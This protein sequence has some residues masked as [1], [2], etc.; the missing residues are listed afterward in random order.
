MPPN[1][2]VHT[3]TVR[4]LAIVVLA[5]VA[6]PI[7]ARAESW[8]ST[9]GELLRTAKRVEMLDVTRIAGATIDAQLAVAVRTTSAVGA[10]IKVEMPPYMPQ[11]PIAVGDRIL[12]ICDQLCPRAI[13][14]ERGGTFEVV[15]Q[16]PG[17]T[18]K[19]WPDFVERDSVALLAS[20]NQAPDVCL[21]GT[22]ALLDEAVGPRFRVA[23]TAGAGS[24]QGDLDGERVTAQRMYLDDLALS[25]PGVGASLRV[26]RSGRLAK[27]KD[28]CHTG[29]FTLVGPLPRSRAG[30]KRVLAGTAAASVLA[31]GT[32]D[33]AAGTA[34]AAGRY[35]FTIEIDRDGQLSV[36]SKLASGSAVGWQSGGTGGGHRVYFPMIKKPEI[37]VVDFGGGTSTLGIAQHLRAAGLSVATLV[38]RPDSTGKDTPLGSMK[39]TYVPEP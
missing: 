21:A 25:L 28:G 36:A 33:V 24:G 38:T 14:V 13:G 29:S 10:S 16:Q 12:V 20:A 17:N 15:A 35:P 3:R 9:M 34:V 19:V 32:L 39:L 5:L 23:L 18:A 2:A 1:V 8:G 11:L 26:E 31:R 7:P 27:A 6:V 37:V 22:F 4:A 30:L